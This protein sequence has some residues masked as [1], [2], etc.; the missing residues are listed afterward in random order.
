MTRL[1][2]MPPILAA[3]IGAAL[4]LVVLA[5]VVGIRRGQAAR[6]EALERD[7]GPDVAPA[8]KALVKQL[9]IGAAVV[10]P[11]DELL[12][13]NESA[14]R[15]GMVKG[16]RIGFNKLLYKVRET[17]AS[18][19][20]FD[21]DLE[22]EAIPGQPELRLRVRITEIDEDQLIVIGYDDAQ[23]RRVEAVR[24]D[25]VANVSHEL[26]TPIGAIGVL[27]EAVEAAKDDPQAVERFSGRLQRE[28]ARLAELVNQIINLSRL[29]STDPLME[30]DEVS[31]PEVV[32]DAIG[33]CREAAAKRD[34]TVITGATSDT[35]VNGDRWQLTEAITNLIQNAI[36]Y[37][38]EGARVVLSIVDVTE[39]GEPFVELKV[40]DNGIGIKPEDQ[41]RIFERFYRVDYGRSR[42]T[43]GTGLGLSIVRHIVLAHGGT[44]RVWSNPGQ[45][46]TFTLR[47]PALEALEREKEDS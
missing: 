2:D 21:G 30:R 27:A 14:A 11:H 1:R 13:S 24:R 32:G 26:K 37:S 36:N 39:D 38:D 16:S 34:V 3:L 31:M 15:F 43:G 8:V 35:S 23:S 5:F 42:S 19:Q 20:P 18:E 4:T 12:V 40:S 6:R 41:E 9:P 28:T 22:R 17:R 7:L 33:R 44:I 47:F 29:Q 46:S 10:G 45:G 25:F